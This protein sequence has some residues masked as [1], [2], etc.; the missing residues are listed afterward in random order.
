MTQYNS[1][2]LLKMNGELGTNNF[3]DSF[4]TG[5][6]PAL[7]LLTTL[8]KLCN[9]PDLLMEIIRSN[10]DNKLPE[11]VKEM[12]LSSLQGKKNIDKS[13]SNFSKFWS[14]WSLSC[15]SEIALCD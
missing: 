3:C 1:L 8:K 4:L 7:S 5:T 6:S 11:R 15:L 9:T 13:K 10:P 14:D 2:S 12:V